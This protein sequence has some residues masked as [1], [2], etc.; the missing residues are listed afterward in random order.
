MAEEN[1]QHEWFIVNVRNG[2]LVTEGCAQTGARASFFSLEDTPP[3]D[4]YV[5]GEYIWKYLGSAQAV[6][7]DLE[8]EKCGKRINLDSI[9]GLMLC[10][11]CNPECNAGQ[12]SKLVG[13]GKTWVYV[14]LCSDTSHTGGKCVDPEE[15]KALTE[16][17]NSKI[18][19]P[20]KRVLFVPCS[21]V[22]NFDTCQGE[23]IADKGLTAIY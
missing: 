19:T 9:M 17:F 1:S 15:T 11:N 20:G 8:C 4:S 13:K 12:L 7:F 2:Y 23:V 18:K 3:V 16:Y 21:F 6:K 10:T 5:Q 22:I 14:A